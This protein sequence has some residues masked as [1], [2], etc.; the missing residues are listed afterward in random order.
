MNEIQTPEEQ[1]KARR[2]RY[3]ELDES[4]RLDIKEKTIDLEVRNIIKPYVDKSIQDLTFGILEL[5]LERIARNEDKDLI[6]TTGEIA[7]GNRLAEL[8]IDLRLSI[9][10]ILKSRLERISM[11][12][13]GMTNKE[14][15]SYSN[16]KDVVNKII[17]YI[18]S[19][20][21]DNS[22]WK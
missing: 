2:R 3:A 18:E 21:S 8:T 6:K 10:S 4:P 13:I 5:Y 22:A 1:L 16:E 19:I 11:K 7:A 9:I 12:Q 17:D 20:D 14:E 15:E